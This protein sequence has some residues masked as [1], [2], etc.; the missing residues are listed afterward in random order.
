MATG[1]N[2]QTARLLKY[3]NSA[4]PTAGWLMGNVRVSADR[5]QV[6]DAQATKQFELL[7]ESL[8]LLAPTDVQLVAAAP[9]IT[10]GQST[11]LTARVTSNGESVTSGSVK[12]TLGDQV[13]ATVPVNGTG[14]AMVVLD[15]LTVSGSPYAV[16]AL[17]LPTSLYL[18]NAGTVNLQVTPATLLITPD[19]LQTKLYGAAMPTLT[20]QASGFVP[21]D[22]PQILVGTLG[23]TAQA[24]SPV[25]TYP[26]LVTGLNAGANYAIQLNGSATFAISPAPLQIS[27]DD[28][29]KVYGS[30]NP[31]LTA[32][33]SGLVNND[34]A[35]VVT[36]LAL[37]TTATLNSLPSSI[38]YPITASGATA[39]NY[40][41]QYVAGGLTVTAIEL[42]T[43]GV[44]FTH[45]GRCTIQW[46]RGYFYRTWPS[47][48]SQFIRRANRLG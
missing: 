6:V 7:F 41:I 4:F 27:A 19:V 37:S 38:P 23:T 36:G 35:S 31:T 9:S 5:S 25:G 21:G 44:T 34:N 12:F 40:E 1:K 48:A 2:Y 46:H 14:R 20:Y 22:D 18:S 16:E 33:I 43:S 10:Y 11:T 13:L 29:S 28:K 45:N 8:T 3:E 17:Y 39:T 42:S 30:Q 32:T 47:S 26:Y 24:S 15:A